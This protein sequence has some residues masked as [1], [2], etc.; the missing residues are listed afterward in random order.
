MVVGKYTQTIQ[1]WLKGK[2]VKSGHGRRYK[3][4]STVPRIGVGKT[5]EEHERKNIIERKQESKKK[6]KDK[7]E[8]KKQKKDNTVGMH[9]QVDFPLSP[10]KSY[11][12]LKRKR[13]FFCWSINYS[14]LIPSKPL[15]P[16]VGS[17][18]WDINYIKRKH[19]SFLVS[20]LLLQTKSDL[21][22]IFFLTNSQCYLPF[23]LLCKS[24]HHHCNYV[25]LVGIIRSFSIKKD[26]RLFFLLLLCLL[27]MTS[28]KQLCLP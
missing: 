21:F 1:R 5:R 8:N 6:E 16:M 14:G 20:S 17:L 13:D 27:A 26:G 28:L 7:K 10:S 3:K 12:L 4:T 11:P 9:Q 2:I 18:S 25:S 22:Y 15:I 24:H 19:S 23:Y